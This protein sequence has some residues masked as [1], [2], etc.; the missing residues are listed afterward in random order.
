MAEELGDPDLLSGVVDS[1]P[2]LAMEMADLIRFKTY[3][4]SDW[5]TAQRRVGRGDCLPKNRASRLDVR[6]AAASPSGMVNGR[7][8]HLASWVLACWSSQVSGTGIY[9]GASNG[10]ASTRSG[11]RTC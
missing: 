10:V 9:N 4:D 3:A 1:P 11:K 7:A 2:R 8:F 6:R 5:P